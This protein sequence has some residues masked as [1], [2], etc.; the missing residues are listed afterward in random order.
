MR[1]AE[2]MDVTM[3]AEGIESVDELQELLGLG[4]TYGQG[5]LLGVPQPLG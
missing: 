1:F 3:I 4:V 2:E 5:F